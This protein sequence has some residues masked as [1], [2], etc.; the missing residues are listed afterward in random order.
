MPSD[1]PSTPLDAD[2]E[3]VYSNPWFSVHKRAPYHWV[4]QART[5]AVLWL[6]RQDGTVA[7]L[8]HHR[9]AARTTLWELPRGTAKAGESLQDC[10]IRE[11]EE[12]TGFAI[13]R[14][15]VRLLGHLYPDAGLLATRVAVYAARASGT[16]LPGD[17]P[18][19]AQES[20]SIESLRWVTPPMLAALIAAGEIQDGFTL[21]AWGLWMAHTAFL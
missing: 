6:Q 2:S 7:L 21:A 8:S 17:R 15:G 9:T 10:A 4:E 3:I 13:S 18:T 20:A 5:G 19:D 16:L 11:G 12:E 1:H 14:D